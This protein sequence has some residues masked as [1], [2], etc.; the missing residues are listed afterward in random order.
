M[1]VAPT[2]PGV[3]IQEIPSGSRAITGVAT[4]GA[5]FVADLFT[6]LCLSPSDPAG[7]LP[8]GVWSDALALCRDE[9]ALLI[10]IR[11]GR[12]LCRRREQDERA[13]AHDGSRQPPP[14]RRRQ[15]KPQ[16]PRRHGVPGGDAR[17]RRD[18]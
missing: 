10:G 15:L 18:P 1:P 4:A 14:R 12:P 7:N 3:Y 16:V 8:D 6:I 5:G 2:Y 11:R 9:R 17:A 13:Q